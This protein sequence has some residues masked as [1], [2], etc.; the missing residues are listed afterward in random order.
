MAP[1]KEKNIL[2]NLGEVRKETRRGERIPGRRKMTEAARQGDEMDKRLE[3]QGGQG[4]CA[5]RCTEEADG[6]PGALKWWPAV[7]P[8]RAVEEEVRARL[9][10]GTTSVTSWGG[11]EAAAIVVRIEGQKVGAEL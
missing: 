7:F 9:L 8:S 10:R 2:A 11:G 3:G 6:I 4:R 1:C 5:H